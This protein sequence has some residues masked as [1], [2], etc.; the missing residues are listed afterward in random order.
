MMRRSRTSRC[1]QHRLLV[2][3]L[4]VAGLVLAAC[5]GGGQDDATSTVRAVAPA[6]TALVNATTTID[7]PQSTAAVDTAATL[8]ALA[9]E[10]LT[11]ATAMP[12]GTVVASRLPDDMGNGNM[13]EIA[14]ENGTLSVPSGTTIEVYA[15]D[16]D[17]PR[18]MALAPDGAVLVTDQS[19]R[20]LRVTDTDGDGVTEV[21]TLLDGL[22]NPHGIAV[23]EQWLIV[24]EETQV[25]RA[26]FTPAGDGVGPTEVIIDDLPVGGHSTRTVRVGPD[27]M[28]YVSIGSSCNVCEEDDPRRATIMRYPFDGGEGELFAAGLRNAVGITFD[29]QGRLWATNNGRDGLGDDVPPETINLVTEGDD[30][31]WPHCHAGTIADPDFGD[32]APCDAVT[33]PTVEMQAHSAPLGLAFL[34]DAFVPL[35][36]QDDLLV[37]FHGSWNR[38]DP[39]GYKVVRV[40]FAD[41]GYTGEVIDFISGWL[42]DDGDVWGR[43]VDLLVM[44]DGNILI[45]DDSTGLLYRLRP[46]G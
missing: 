12:T 35:E 5:G 23:H 31:G 34:T 25:V 20:V 4:I 33:A 40:V 15:R 46:A 14:L 3:V 6:A 11:T 44:P 42:P 21:T 8:S 38:S 7:V 24:A 2:T 16:L 28:L 1:T 22:R 29:L 32:A 39:T 37:A 9:T 36:W 17:S 19:G 18:F 10:P 30:F 26:A 41:G 45:S 27:S 43:P 13:T